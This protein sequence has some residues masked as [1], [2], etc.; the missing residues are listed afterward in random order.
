MKYDGF[1]LPQGCVYINEI[2]KE[3]SVMITDI[4]YYEDFIS[5]CS[6]LFD[7]YNEAEKLIYKDKYNYFELIKETLKDFENREVIQIC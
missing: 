7:D 3:N 6:H 4:A 1:Q 2:K 5:E